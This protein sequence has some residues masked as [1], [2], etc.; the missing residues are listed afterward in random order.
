MPADKTVDFVILFVIIGF[1]VAGLGSV[2]LGWAVKRYDMFMSRSPAPAPQT[3]QTD[4]TDSYVSEADL[5]LDRLE[6]DRTKTA[7]IELLVYS[8]WEVGQ[9]RGVIKGD[10]GTIGAEVQAAKIRLGMVDEP[11]H[12]RVK[13]D[14]GERLIP[15]D[16]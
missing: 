6:V 9:I 16:A 11:R 4:T 14:H 8:G 15:M 10:N 12:L 1:I 13:D 5:W 7:L 2:A 3:A